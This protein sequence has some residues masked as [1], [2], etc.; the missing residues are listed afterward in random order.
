MVGEDPVL[1]L[2]GRG[3]E[4]HCGGPV[5]EADK[6]LVFRLM[7]GVLVRAAHRRF[8]CQGQLHQ[9]PCRDIGQDI[10]IDKYPERIPQDC[11]KVLQGQVLSADVVVS[12]E[13]LDA[14]RDGGSQ[15]DQ[16]SL[17]FVGRNVEFCNGG[18]ALFLNSGVVQQY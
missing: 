4:L 13:E 8:I 10:A 2:R 3:D 14:L 16:E 11:V 17:G 15:G 9:S 12:H 6:F 5:D 1:R 7:P 18:I